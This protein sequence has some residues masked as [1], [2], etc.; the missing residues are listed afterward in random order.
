MEQTISEQI[1]KEILGTKERGIPQNSY[2]EVIFEDNSFT[3]E[4]EI[5]WSSISEQVVVKFGE[6]TKVVMLCNVP[7]K[8]A[9]CYA[10]D[11]QIEVTPDLTKGDKVYQAVIST[12]TFIPGRPTVNQHV[13]RLLGVVRDGQVIEEKYIDLRTNETHGIIL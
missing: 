4:K 8:T 1:Q 11:L 7:V 10:G 3:T 5:N 2:F 13:G 9:K 6:R 12:S